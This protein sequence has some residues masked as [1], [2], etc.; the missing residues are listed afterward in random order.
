MVQLSNELD[1]R[2]LQADRSLEHL[3]NI[4][5]KFGESAKKLESGQD[6]IFDAQKQLLKIAEE[7]TQTIKG[8]ET[9]QTGAKQT[10]EGAMAVIGEN[11]EKLNRAIEEWQSRHEKVLQLI[12]DSSQQARN[13]LKQ[14]RE[15]IHQGFDGTT[16]LIKT[17]L[18]QQLGDLKTQALEMMEQQQNGTRQHLKEVV[19]SQSGF[20]RELQV[21]IASSDGHREL[22]SGLKDTLKQEKDAFTERIKLALEAEQELFANYHGELVEQNSE[23][24]GKVTEIITALNSLLENGASVQTTPPDNSALMERLD[25]ITRQLQEIARPQILN[26]PNEQPAQQINL[27][28]QFKRLPDDARR[29]VSALRM[30][31]GLAVFS[32]TAVTLSITLSAMRYWPN[33]PINSSFTLL[34]V[35]FISVLAGVGLAKAATKVNRG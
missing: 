14:S 16:N 8:L 11:N 26:P 7:F 25:V 21:A 23:F 28:P 1:N 2:V 6:Q 30:I 34:G 29:I 18:T 9:H 12:Q 27:G 19:E 31:I 5:G 22:L 4:V 13:D 15:T 35:L 10:I 32:I 24:I 3:F 20:V 33:D 17:T